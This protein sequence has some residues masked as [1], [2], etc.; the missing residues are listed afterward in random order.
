MSVSREPALEVMNLRTIFPVTPTFQQRL[1][2]VK[3]AVHAVDGVSFT[4]NQGETLGLVGES[5]CGKSTLGRSLL[6]LI[7][8]TSG[9]IRI[10]G[11]P[12]ADA[13]SET[14]RRLRQNAQ[15][16]FQDPS[17]SLNPRFT[18]GQTLEEPL[19]I[20]R[21]GDAASRRS[22][23]RE[24]L[25]LVGL[26]ADAASRY[27][28]QLSGGQRQRVGIAAALALQP[29]LVVADEPT[30]ALDVS[31]QAQ[32][33]NLMKDIQKESNLAYLFISHNL[34]VVRYLSDRVAVMYL[35]KIVELG[36]ADQV[37]SDPLHP[38]TKA[39]LASVPGSDPEHRKRMLL[40]GE[41]PS[42]I[43]PPRGC[44]FHPRCPIAKD[45]CARIDPPLIEEDGH[46]VACHAVLWARSQRVH[47]DRLPGLEQWQADVTA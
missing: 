9:E 23:V 35:G 7:K 13:S 29:K 18:I 32:I 27:P 26:P 20:F 24:L 22:R 34:D 2:G 21:I 12:I 39:L 15:I 37:M 46:A 1:Q 40:E 3:R 36:A 11:S 16:I 45:L 44:R 42:P 31:V 28:H 25:D 4:I 14:L 38:Y 43:D 8:P 30:S 5:G 33:L 6:R 41:P 47:T 10:D 19:I 17:A